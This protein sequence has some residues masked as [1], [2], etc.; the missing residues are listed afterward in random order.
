MPEQKTT[1]RYQVVANGPADDAEPKD[2]YFTQL[3]SDWLP[4]REQ[5]IAAMEALQE[6]GFQAHIKTKEYEYTTDADE[7]PEQTA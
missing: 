4:R 6:R 1:Y 2:P 5:A 3:R 7:V